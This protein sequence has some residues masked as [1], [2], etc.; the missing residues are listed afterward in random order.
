MPD[1]RLPKISVVTPS[2]NQGRFIED[3]ILS[4]IGQGYPNLEYIVIDGGSTDETVEVLK[5][6]DD[7]ITYWVS[8]KD[9]GQASALNKGFARATGDILCWLNSDDMYLPG[10]LKYISTRLDISRPEMLIGNCVHIREGTGAAIGSDIVSDCRRHDIAWCSYVIQ[11][12]SFWTRAVW[13]AAG[14]LDESLNYALDWDWFIRAKMAK[15]EFIAVERHLS[16]YRIHAAHK[17]SFGGETRAKEL[18]GV[19][20]RYHNA[21]GV[22]LFQ[23][24][25]RNRIRAAV[26]RRLI[27]LPYIYTRRNQGLDLIITKAPNKLA[28]S[29]LYVLGMLGFRFVCPVLSMRYSTQEVRDVLRML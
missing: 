28:A 9:S 18:G 13:E 12:S 29:L 10:T 3:T 4:V 8:E 20:K 17:S 7:K 5:K 1:V 14:K 19:Y 6:Y 24:L 15:A 27:D 16:V 22:E 26:I 23:V 25:R 21:R 2:Y 11:P